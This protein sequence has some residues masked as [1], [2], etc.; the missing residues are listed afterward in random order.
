MLIVYCIYFL[1]KATGTVPGTPQRVNV[2]PK[3]NPISSAVPTVTAPKKN[4]AKTHSTANASLRRLSD[5]VPVVVPRN[6]ARFE[7]AAEI[8]KE[9]IGRMMPLSLQSKASDFRKVSSI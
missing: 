6:N 4:S 3:T 2:G 5:V 7:Q 1:G 9:G 8:R